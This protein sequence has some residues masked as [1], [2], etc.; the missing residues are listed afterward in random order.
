MKGFAGS[1]AVGDMLH[2]NDCGLRSDA[3][4]EFKRQQWILAWV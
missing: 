2:G 1:P 3:P 4:R